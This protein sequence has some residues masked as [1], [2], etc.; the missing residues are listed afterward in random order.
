MLALHELAILGNMRLI[1]QRATYLINLDKDYE[2]FARK[3]R[4]LAD[5]YQEKAILS[6]VEQ[7]MNKNEDSGDRT[8]G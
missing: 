3:L 1:R 5:A 4:D 8:D 2:P 7:H 6:L